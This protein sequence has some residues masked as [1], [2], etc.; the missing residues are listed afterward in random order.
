[1]WLLPVRGCAC[2]AAAFKFQERTA[3]LLRA[4]AS[5]NPDV[6]LLQECVPETWAAICAGAEELGYR[7]ATAQ[8]PEDG[9]FV[10]VLS[11]W[12]LSGPTEF[13]F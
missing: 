4:I 11:R 8:S 2:N 10:G 1:M 9:Y 5:L 7:D 6:L 12:P 13:S 3:G